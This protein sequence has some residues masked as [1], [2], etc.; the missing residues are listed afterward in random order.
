MSDHKTNGVS[1]AKAAGKPI[2]EV[3]LTPL[4]GDDCGLAGFQIVGAFTQDAPDGPMK[5]SAVLVATGGRTSQIAMSFEPK[6]IVL[7]ELWSDTV[8]NLRAQ[9]MPPAH[10]EKQPE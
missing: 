1:L 3:N 2:R 4:G 10:P 7:R 8:E 6:T 5:I 9:L